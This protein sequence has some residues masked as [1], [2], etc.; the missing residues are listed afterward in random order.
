MSNACNFFQINM[1]FH[2]FYCKCHKKKVGFC[3]NKLA[4]VA[5]STLAVLTLG[6]ESDSCDVFS[7]VDVTSVA[8][9]IPSIY[10]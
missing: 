2:H 1:I 10:L 3:Y 7:L 9:H 8:P 4:N 6:D 5:Y